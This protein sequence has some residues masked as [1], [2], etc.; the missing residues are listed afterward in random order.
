MRMH[1]RLNPMSI[2]LTTGAPPSPCRGNKENGP[3]YLNHNAT[4]VKIEEASAAAYNKAVFLILFIGALLLGGNVWFWLCFILKR[5]NFCCEGFNGAPLLNVELDLDL[6][7]LDLN[8]PPL[9]ENF[10]VCF[11]ITTEFFP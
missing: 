8:D 10:P 9:L 2:W 7:V 5:R 11:S 4:L 3:I 6:L 1:F